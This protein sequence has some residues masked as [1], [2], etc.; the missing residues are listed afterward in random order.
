[1][2]SSEISTPKDK[3]THPLA[4]RIASHWA[5]RGAPRRGLLAFLGPGLITGASDD[6]PSGIATYSQVGAQFGYG[7]AWVMLFSYPLMV[8]IQEVSARIGR[9][10]GFGIAGNLRR[11]YPPWLSGSIV[12]LLLSAN[13]INLGA[14]LGAM[15]A[16]LKLLIG[17]PALIYVVLFGAL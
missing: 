5:P 15:V 11:H 9:V 2:T 13:L 16:A 4:A 10:T 6:D 8:A 1:M 14:D 7:M 17:G 12:L 3:T